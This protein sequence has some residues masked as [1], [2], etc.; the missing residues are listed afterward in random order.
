MVELKPA[1][2]LFFV[3]V[4][5]LTTGLLNA[6]SC[7][8]EC[9]KIRD[10]VRQIQEKEDGQM[11]STGRFLLSAAPEFEPGS[12]EFF[13]GLV[14]FLAVDPIRTA[15]MTHL[16]YRHRVNDRV[17]SWGPLFYENTAY[18]RRK[19]IRIAGLFDEHVHLSLVQKRLKFDQLLGSL[20]SDKFDDF[21]LESN[22]G[23]MRSR[24]L[25]SRGKSYMIELTVHF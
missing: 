4:L 12:K 3:G 20:W 15:K 13:P 9:A 14:K 8:A 22:R 23:L 6:D 16:L 10:L 25:F 11:A 5:V 7:K 2:Q 19:G 18:F 24:T 21:V 17:R 1:H